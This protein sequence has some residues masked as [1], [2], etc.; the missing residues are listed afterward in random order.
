MIVTV[1]GSSGD[2]NAYVSVLSA[3]GSLLIAGASRWDDM[4]RT[5][6]FG[7]RDGGLS[8]APVNAQRAPAGR[9][10]PDRAPSPHG[11][12][13]STRPGRSADRGRRRPAAL[14]PSCAF[15]RLPPGPFRA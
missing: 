9:P 2:T 11:R 14:I 4:R 1:L 3:T 5:S 10:A 7:E 12:R 6:S 15:P 13:A 8:G